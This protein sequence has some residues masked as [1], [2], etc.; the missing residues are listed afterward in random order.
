[1]LSRRQELALQYVSFSG[2]GLEIGPAYDPIAPKDLGFNV[3]VLDHASTTEI[4]EK[5]GRLGLAQTEVDRIEEVDCVWM[6][7][8]YSETPGLKPPYDF[9]IASHV[10]EHT[11]DLIG[12]LSDL[13]D[14]LG[15]DGRIALVVPDKR[16]CF[17]HH[18]PL[19]TVGAILEAHLRP[20]DFHTP[21]VIF[22]HFAY[23]V[24]FDNN[25]VWSE[26]TSG[27]F[28]PNYSVQRAWSEAQDALI[29][30]EYIDVHRWVF[31]PSSFQ[32]VVG[33][34]SQGGWL[35]LCVVGSSP[36]SG[37]EFYATLG[38]GRDGHPTEE[39]LAFVH[40]AV[41][42]EAMT[43][44][45]QLRIKSDRELPVESAEVARELV[46]RGPFWR[47]LRAD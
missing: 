30:T 6:G 19:S 23:H 16:F 13:S 27:V 29:S 12:F 2:K 47:R 39:L 7:G 10:I 18:R 31:T 46:R 17:D 33:A 40:D 4:R 28:R 42:E 8:K 1:M 26:E 32:F 22:D 14:L 11:V 36:T 20:T 44:I 9:I 25:I 15:P 43:N 41:R 45:S 21:G 3:T 38:R 34:L 37:C 5:Y 24:G 35:D